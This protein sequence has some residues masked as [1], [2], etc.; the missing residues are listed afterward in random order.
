MKSVD[1]ETDN[2][3][4]ENQEIDEART[5]QTASVPNINE[6]DQPIALSKDVVDKDSDDEGEDEE[7]DYEN[8][9][10]EYSKERGEVYAEGEGEKESDEQPGGENSNTHE[11]GEEEMLDIAETI[12]NAIAQ[13]LIARNYT[14]R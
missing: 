4:N 8:D 5:S 2:G 11:I 12:F 7:E 3:R 6:K 9:S 13:Q 10:E 14:V 1:E